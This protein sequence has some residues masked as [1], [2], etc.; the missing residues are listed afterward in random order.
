MSTKKI[1]TNLNFSGDPPNKKIYDTFDFC[2]LNK[3][4]LLIF[5][6]RMLS[7]DYI[8]YISLDYPDLDKELLN[9]ILFFRKAKLKSEEKLFKILSDYCI[10]I[11]EASNKHVSMM[12]LQFDLSEL[13]LHDYIFTLFSNIENFCEN[14]IKLL[15]DYIYQINLIITP[16][17]TLKKKDFGTLLNH[18]TTK[19]IF[20][21]LFKTEQNGLELNQWR[22]IS[23]HKDFKIKDNI[24]VCSYGKNR[25]KEYIIEK[26]EDLLLFFYHIQKIGTIVELAF[27]LFIY[28]N[29]YK[30]MSIFKK[31]NKEPTT[32]RNEVWQNL[33]NSE[34][35][36]MGFYLDKIEII[37]DKINIYIIDSSN[38]FRLPQTGELILKLYK[39]YKNFNNINLIYYNKNKKPLS[40]VTTSKEFCEKYYSGLPLESLSHLLKIN[41]FKVN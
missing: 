1:L 25:E 28:D 40:A 24:T 15:L 35:I 11:L 6:K 36:I 18:V 29:Y 37:K 5:S 17:Q 34:L 30:I 22:N 41:I 7:D 9:M 38:Y 21:S 10:D 3:N 13:S 4:N 20:S 26:K 12:N 2:F 39:F 8:K 19:T 23:C 33:Y 27:D 31:N 32:I 16:D 14:S